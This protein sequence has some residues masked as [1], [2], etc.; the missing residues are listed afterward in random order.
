[1]PLRMKMNFMNDNNLRNLYFKNI[2]Q[3][4]KQN[5]FS[6]FSYYGMI[7]RLENSATCGSCSK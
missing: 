3:R 6:K 4:T 2:G 5:R 1:M 7:G